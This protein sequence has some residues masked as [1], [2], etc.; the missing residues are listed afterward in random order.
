MILVHSGDI[1]KVVRN[2]AKILTFWAANNGVEFLGKRSPN[3]LTKFCKDEKEEE[4][5][6]GQEV[7]E[8]EEE[9]E[10]KKNKNN[11]GLHQRTDDVCSTAELV[12]LSTS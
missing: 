9:V 6:G 8:E 3:F 11:N 2:R 4:E 5:E 12:D 7:E 1:R 10:K